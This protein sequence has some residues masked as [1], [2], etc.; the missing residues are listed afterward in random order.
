MMPR[1]I[2]LRLGSLEREIS[3]TTALMQSGLARSTCCIYRPPPTLCSTNG[4]VAYSPQVVSIGPYRRYTPNPLA[5]VAMDNHKVEFISLLLQRTHLGLDD[6][7]ERIRPLEMEARECYPNDWELPI[8]E[9]LFL[10]MIVLDGCFLI[11]LFRK[12]NKE[13]QDPLATIPRAVPYVYGDL[14]MIGNQ[15]PFSV[16][17]ELFDTTKM[18]DESNDSLSLLALQF[19]YK[20]MQRPKEVIE[21]LHNQLPPDQKPL[22]LLDL[23]RSSFL[24]PLPLPLPRRNNETIRLIPSVSKLRRA[25]IK[26]KPTRKA[27]S[28]LDVKFR[29]GVINMPNIVIDHCMKT[30]LLNCV[31]FEELHKSLSKQFTVYASFLDCLVDIK[32]DAGHLCEQNIF[33]SYLGNDDDV[34]QFINNMGKDLA[35]A[36]DQFYLSQL[37]EDVNERYR[38]P[39]KLQWASFKST[40]FNTPW[41][42]ISALAAFVLLVLTSLQTFYTIYAY[43]HPKA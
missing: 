4:G 39:F 16:L 32:W 11:E 14:L 33:D 15:I 20:V 40:Y 35:F 13:S 2:Y 1:N 3:E 8:D 21:K 12:A 28:F 36:D 6:L 42:L 31:A 19:F 38:S 10:K 17:E 41:T 30:F 27:D 23:V 7:L 37:F 26:V 29:N 43:V 9:D 18:Q 25:G 5:L 22:H 34:V 24:T